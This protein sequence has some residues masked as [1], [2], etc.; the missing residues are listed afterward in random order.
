MPSRLPTSRQFQVNTVIAIKTILQ[1]LPQSMVNE[2]QDWRLLLH[3]QRMSFKD[4]TTDW[5]ATITRQIAERL[6]KDKAA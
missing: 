3:P 1:T 4:I 6:P 2:L 5:D